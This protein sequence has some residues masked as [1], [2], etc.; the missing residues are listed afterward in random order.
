M[1]LC[2]SVY[3]QLA[4]PVQQ[5]ALEKLLKFLVMWLYY[6][7]ELEEAG[8]LAE[9]VDALAR[10]MKVAEMGR[11]AWQELIDEGREQGI[12]QGREQGIQQAQQETLLRLLCEKFGRVP[13]EMERR[14]RTTSDIERLGAWITRVLSADTLEAMGI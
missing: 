6:R 1:K 2:V 4:P 7:R 10:E 11:T 5:G 8:A 14:V 12:Q 13:P 3:V 9:R